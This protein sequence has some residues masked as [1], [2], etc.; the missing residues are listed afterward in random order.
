VVTKHFESLSAD[1]QD[2]FIASMQWMEQYWDEAA[3]LLWNIKDTPFA[4][5]PHTIRGSTWYAI[6]L[7]MRQQPGDVS[8]AVRTKA[9]DGAIARGLSA[10][11][12]N[13][14]LMYTFML[15]FAG[16]RLNQP[17]W[18]NPSDSSSSA[19]DLSIARNVLRTR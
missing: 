7:L 9:V 1:A 11:Y 17:A 5:K 15:Y 18:R 14:A 13:I 10:R 4:S 6:G 12:A 3:G 2:L 8:R 19:C 16:K